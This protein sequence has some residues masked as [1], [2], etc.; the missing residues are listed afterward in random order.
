VG[1][2]G[3]WE[4]AV[5]VHPQKLFLAMAALSRTMGPWVGTATVGSRAEPKEHNPL[6]AAFQFISA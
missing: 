6:G 4:A 1:S 5:P 3:L 2:T